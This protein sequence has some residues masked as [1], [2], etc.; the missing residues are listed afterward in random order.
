MRYLIIIILAFILFVPK[1]HAQEVSVEK[2]L[3]GIQ[4]LIFPLSVY[5]E[6]KFTP[7]IALRSEWSGALA[8]RE[9]EVIMTIRYNGQLSHTLVLNHVTIT[10]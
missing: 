6:A 3:W 4:T 8:G 7:N 9:M 10:T 5:N 2:N 1:G